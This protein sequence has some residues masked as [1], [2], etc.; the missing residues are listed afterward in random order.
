M[1][2][3]Q[4]ENYLKKLQELDEQISDDSENDELF[5]EITK[6]I[7]DLTFDIQKGVD[8]KTSMAE[9]K[10]VNLS[11]NPDPTFSHE[12]DSGF[13]LRAFIDNDVIID[14]F[15]TKLI[16]TGLYFQVNKGL[17]VQVRPRSGISLKNSVIVTNS[18]GTINNL[19]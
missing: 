8:K 6:V 17:E 19:N 2:K 11:N 12:G 9:L 16:P 5:N 14:Q 15:E 18:P 7:S 4:I 13:D 10:F 1:E 3:N